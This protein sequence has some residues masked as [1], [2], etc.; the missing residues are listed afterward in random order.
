MS[1]EEEI[2]KYIVE[3][4]KTS[5][6]VNFNRKVTEKE[7]AIILKY[8]LPRM[9]KELKEI[10]KFSDI[11]YK[12]YMKKQANQLLFSP[13]NVIS[14]VQ[15]VIKDFGIE[16][17]IKAR[18]YKR[19]REM[20]LAA[21]FCLAN[22]KIK[23]DMLMI[24]PQDSPDIILVLPDDASTKNIVALPME[25]M[26]VPEIVKVN[27]ATDLPKELAN[28]IKEKK[29]KKAYGEIFSLLVGFDFTQENLNFNRISE[30]LNKISNNP[31]QSIFATFTSSDDGKRMSVI[32]LYPGVTI[33]KDYILEQEQNLLY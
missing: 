5:Y 28:F 1:T 29:F 32:K 9:E 6:M 19:L 24:M 15:R 20:E 31:Y 33:R 25:I 11:E 18:E 14:E 12:I 30:E 10:K 23:G 17:M 2:K 21:R 8:L 27:M 3:I 4:A 13:G 16:K 22:R 26:I 7:I